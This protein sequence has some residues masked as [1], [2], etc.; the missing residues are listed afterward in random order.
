LHKITHTVDIVWACIL[1][2]F[3]VLRSSA[4]LQNTTE[5]VNR[6]SSFSRCV[7]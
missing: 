6:I 3:V 4:R 5:I 7:G 1:L 2:N